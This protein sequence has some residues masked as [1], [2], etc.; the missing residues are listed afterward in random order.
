MQ[1]LASS[2][3]LLLQPCISM[4]LLHADAQLRPPAGCAWRSYSLFTWRLHNVFVGS[5]TGLCPW[6]CWRN[7]KAGMMKWTSRAGKGGTSLTRSRGG[8]G[9]EGGGPD[10]AASV[11]QRGGPC[12]ASPPLLTRL[13]THMKTAGRPTSQGGVSAGGSKLRSS[14][15]GFIGSDGVR[16][17]IG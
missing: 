11:R 16:S 13:Y 12:P 6:K 8:R 3:P 5:G 10:I 2:G 15:I 1:L 17:K 14:L 4:S 7:G 9:G